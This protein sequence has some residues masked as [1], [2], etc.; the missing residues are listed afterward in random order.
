MINNPKR[1][2]RKKKMDKAI[3]SDQI[4][5]L[6]GLPN[7]DLFRISE[8]ADYFSVTERTIRLWVDHGHFQIEKHRGTIWIP[9][10]SILQ[11]R[12]RSRVINS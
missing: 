4:I 6:N 5:E 1:Q 12:I 9:R 2:T 7:R 8:V 10:G 3:D 11:F